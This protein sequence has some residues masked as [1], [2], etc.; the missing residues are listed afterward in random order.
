MRWLCFGEVKMIHYH[1]SPLGTAQDLPTFYTGRH[2]LVS[3]AHPGDLGVIMECAQTFCLDNGA[4]S[5]WKSGTPVDWDAYIVWVKALSRHPNF[6]FWL[7]PDVIDGTEDD[8]WRLMFKYGRSIPYAVPV[9]HFHESLEYL[10]K[11]VVNYPRIALGSSAQWATVGTESWWSRMAEIMTVC[12][13]SDGIPR[14]KLHGLRM[15]D[16][17]V[18]SRLPLSS[19]DSCNAVINSKAIK[20]F[21]MYPPGS[22]AGRAAVIANRIE[23]HNCCPIWIPHGQE[24]FQFHSAEL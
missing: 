21:G 10:E 13:D 4:F 15:L 19:A 20:R 2:A 7:I 12:C 18:F 6:D 16:T 17:G 11:L 3:Y 1:G 23:A 22:K 5:F 8:N 9:Y 14:T 24:A